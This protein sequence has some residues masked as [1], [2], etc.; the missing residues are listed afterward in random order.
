MYS[1]QTFL[2]CHYEW[3]TKAKSRA[4]LAYSAL[5]KS[6]PYACQSVTD[7]SIAFTD[8]PTP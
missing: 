4:T 7:I 6:Q 8:F 2:F 5:I 1:M 3:D